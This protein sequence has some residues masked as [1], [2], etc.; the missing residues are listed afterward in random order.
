V[1]LPY[2]INVLTQISAKFAFDH[3]HVFDQQTAQ[4]KKDRARLFAALSGFPAL[5]VFPSKANFILFKTQAGQSA[6][7]FDAL[8]A[9]GIL[10]KTL[11]QQAGLLTD[12][13]RVTVGTPVENKKFL[14]SLT[15]TL[16]L[17]KS[18]RNVKSQGVAL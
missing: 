12:C 11:N 8:K 4:I 3:K 16:N 2:N 13:L 5:N 6:A 1:R 18:T 17:F 14:T 10:I 7:I 9:D 15:K